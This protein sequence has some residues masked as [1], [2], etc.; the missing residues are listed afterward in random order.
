MQAGRPHYKGQIAL[1]V[2]GFQP[3]IITFRLGV[4]LEAREASRRIRSSRWTWIDPCPSLQ[5]EK[6]RVP[7]IAMSLRLC[8]SALN[9][10]SGTLRDAP[11][12][13]SLFETEFLEPR[14]YELS[15]AP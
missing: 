8:A 3:A 15:R 6:I 11:E 14:S 9:L 12:T 7:F 13:A 4:S 5:S 2:V 1:V 10:R